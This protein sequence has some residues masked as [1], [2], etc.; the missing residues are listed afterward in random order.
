MIFTSGTTN[1][2]KGVILSHYNV[3][4]NAR[5][6]IQSMRWTPEDKMCITVPLFHCFGITAGIISCIVGG[7]SMHLI[8]YFKTAKVWDAIEH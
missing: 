8:P 6:M 5:T 7:M 1:L 4:N 3:V 2:P